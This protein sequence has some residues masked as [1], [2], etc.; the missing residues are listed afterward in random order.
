MSLAARMDEAA[1]LLRAEAGNWLSAP[2]GEWQRRSEV[3]AAAVL[4]LGG[5]TALCARCDHAHSGITEHGL[6]SP[7]GP[8][9]CSRRGCDCPDWT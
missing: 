5:A 3:A 2:E 7:D 8:Q 1:R 9:P 6:Y 4:V